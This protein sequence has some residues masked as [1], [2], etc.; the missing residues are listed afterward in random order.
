[1]TGETTRYSFSANFITG[2]QNRKEY[3]KSK[4]VTTIHSHHHVLYDHGC[5]EDLT[6]A[7]GFCHTI[8]AGTIGLAGGYLLYQQ[9][10]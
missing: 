5:I 1:M 2:K 4:V 3:A 9:K 7:G 8:D 10:S 6:C